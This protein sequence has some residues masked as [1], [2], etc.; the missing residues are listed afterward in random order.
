MSAQTFT[1]N[2]NVFRQKCRCQSAPSACKKQASNQLQ[3][4]LYQTDLLTE[5]I[6]IT[7]KDR[8]ESC[9]DHE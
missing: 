9:L 4:N 5:L 6:L 7:K 3:A 8:R 1:F 2:V